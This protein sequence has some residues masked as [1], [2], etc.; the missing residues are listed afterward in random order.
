ML[1]RNALLKQVA[2]SRKLDITLLQILDEQL[3]F[4]GNKI[5]EKRKKFL[6]D[7]IPLFN[8]H[9]GYITDNAEYVSLNYQSQL[10]D[11]NFEQLLKQSIDKDRILERTT[12]GIHKDELQFAIGDMPL[13]KFGSQGQQKSF[14]IALK[15]AQY[16]YLQK[17]KEFRPL[18]LL[19]DIFDKLDDL[20]VRKLMEMVSHQDFGQIFI[21]DTG[22]ERVISV[23]NQIDI[24]LTLFEVDNGVI[25]HA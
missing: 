13:K 1:N 4:S 10:N 21:T 17:F 25:K 19:D 11:Q 9:Y 12:T 22:K 20:R 23:F 14:L 7:F 24:D 3:I 15:L 8:Q 5:F 16:S 2:V 18:L 6:L